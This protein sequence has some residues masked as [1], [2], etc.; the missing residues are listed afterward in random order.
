MKIHFCDLCNESVPQADL[1]QGRAFIRKDRVICSTCENVMTHG[2][3]PATVT[4][5]AL[6]AAAI[7]AARAPDVAP[8]LP[9]PAPLVAH[10]ENPAHHPHL[11]P[12]V[13]RSAGAGG[14]WVALL[15]LVF[16]AGVMFVLDNRI[17]DIQRDATALDKRVTSHQGDLGVLQRGAALD[18]ATQSDLQKQAERNLEAQ[19]TRQDRLTDQIA[20]LGRDHNELSARIA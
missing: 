9:N 20:E 16:T 1:D 17:Q 2:H 3:P 10:G 5:P 12:I 19:K 15:G 18:K 7:A 11:Q 8:A 6:A 13:V 4:S 14:L